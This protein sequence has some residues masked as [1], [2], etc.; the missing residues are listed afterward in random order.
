MSP[1]IV[2]GKDRE[3]RAIYLVF[4]AH[5]SRAQGQL[6]KMSSSAL[7]PRLYLPSSHPGRSW[8]RS[9]SP[10]SRPAKEPLPKAGLAPSA[11][12]PAGLGP[13][14]AAGLGCGSA[15]SPCPCWRWGRRWSCPE[16][17]RPRGCRWGRGSRARGAAQGTARS[18]SQ[19]QPCSPSPN[20]IF[21]CVWV[22]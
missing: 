8:P 19:A 13:G 10:W 2:F 3:G 22:M 11:R 6:C 1:K 18:S 14:R 17:P 9:G 4:R 21:T 12:A 15:P 5:L 7:S 20:S 16:P